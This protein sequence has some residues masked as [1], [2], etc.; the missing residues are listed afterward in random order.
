MDAP[1]PNP[2]RWTVARLLKWTSGH[3]EQRGVESARLCAEI[4]LSHAMQCARIELYTR[5]DAVPDAGVLEAFRELLRRAADGAPVAYLTG[6]KEFFSLTFEVSPA[7]LIPRPDTEVLVERAIALARQES[8]RIETI[9]DVGTGSGCIAISL[10]KHLPNVRCTAIDIS[11]DALSIARRN[12]ERH[13]ASERIEFQCGDLFA[14]LGEH[15]QFDLIVTN[16]PYIAAAEANSLPRAVREYEPSAALFA[17]SDGFAL[18]RRLATEAQARLRPGGRLLTET[19]FD[20]APRVRELFER[21]GWTEITIYRDDARH[22]R[23]VCAR[24]AVA[25]TS[26][27]A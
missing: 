23:V 7:V 18:H 20:Q 21:A 24:R 19:A 13:G 9:L 17:G 4:L 8:E 27:V 6:Q 16:P 15:D 14:S 25:A 10:A 1:Q 5:H 22:E 11:Q 3:L 2:D 12:A 26:E